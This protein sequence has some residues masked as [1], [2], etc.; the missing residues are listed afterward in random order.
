MVS[1]KLLRHRVVIKCKSMK[2]KPLTPLANAE[3]AMPDH[4]WNEVV[5]TD[6]ESYVLG[7]TLIREL[8][9]VD[10][11]SV[12]ITFGSGGL[13]CQREVAGESFKTR[14][15]EKTLKLSTIKKIELFTGVLVKT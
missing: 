9:R 14:K 6:W 4:L 2:K 13:S 12:F 1:H 11:Y 3:L 10:Q 7:F 5:S 8:L 15:S